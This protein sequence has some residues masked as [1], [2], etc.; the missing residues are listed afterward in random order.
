MVQSHIRS[1]REYRR[2]LFAVIS[3]FGLDSFL[4]SKQS[5][6]PKRQLVGCSSMRA[7]CSFGILYAGSHPPALPDAPNRRKTAHDSLAKAK[8]RCR[9]SDSAP[10]RRRFHERRAKKNKFLLSL[11]QNTVIST[12]FNRSDLNFRFREI[13]K[14]RV[15]VFK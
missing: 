14:I 8:R 15:M 4:W 2:K 3:A 12:K 9:G 13:D 7:I 6:N 10:K 11:N 1:S 5:K